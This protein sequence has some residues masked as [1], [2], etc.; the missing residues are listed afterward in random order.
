MATEVAHGIIAQRGLDPREIDLIIVATITPDMM[1]PATACLVQDRI[2]AKRAWGF[3]L[4]AAC[5]G[6]IYA[7]ATGAQFIESGVHDKV[8][9]VGA[10][11]VLLE[12]TESEGLIDFELHCDGSGGDDLLMPGGGSLNPASKAVED[13]LH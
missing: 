4:S 5:T 6:F 7:V 12:P 3:D 1:F 11:A 8:L 9:V 10:G 2:G 13:R